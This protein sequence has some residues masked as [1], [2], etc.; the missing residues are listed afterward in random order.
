MRR[1][2]IL[3]Y[4]SRPDV[5]RA[6]LAVSRGREVVGSFANGSYARRPDVLLYP[7][8]ILQKVRQSIV[9]FHCSVEHWSQPMALSTELSSAELDRLRTGFD[10]ILDI[11]SKG[12]LEHATAAAIAVCNFLSDFGVTPTVKFSGRRGWHIAI[13]ANAFPAKVDL[14]PITSR[15]PEVPAAVS[16]FIKEKVADKLLEALIEQHGGVAALYGSTVKAPAEL[17]PYTFVDIESGWGIRHLFRA[18][19]SLHERSWLVSLPIR[20]FKLAGFK[21][22]SA[23]PEKAKPAPFL[24]SKNGEA[25]ELLLAAL[26][27]AA[28]RKVHRPRQIRRAWQKTS[29]PEERF[30]P[31]IK[32]IL[33]GLADG[34]KR[35]LFTLLTFL[36]TVGWDRNKIEERLKRWNSAN[37]RPLPKRMLATQLNWHSRRTMMPANCD[38]ELFYK[39]I[40]ICKPDPRCGKNPVN[41]ALRVSRK[42]IKFRKA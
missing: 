12:L 42:A 28:K 41:Y 39:S 11:D 23:K 24:V 26:D 20:L 2:D 35:S 31:C 36:K 25:T 30:P 14:R 10:V 32:A 18:P 8:D 29:V 34:R 22:E 15:Y 38:S 19:C 9:A 5:Q 1:A 37:A 33:A 3:R 40:G 27:W 13:A 21:P 17:S 7:S 16:S 4:Y 6:L